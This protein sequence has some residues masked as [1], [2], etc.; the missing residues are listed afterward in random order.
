MER[1]EMQNALVQSAVHIVAR[2]GIDKVK[3][4]NRHVSTHLDRRR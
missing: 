1:N 2:E 3:V 4:D